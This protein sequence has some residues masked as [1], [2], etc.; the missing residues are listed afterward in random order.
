MWHFSSFSEV[1]FLA[2]QFFE[3]LIEEGN[4]SGDSED[5]IYDIISC[6]Q[7]AVKVVSS[8]TLIRSR[9]IQKILPKAT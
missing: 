6:V 5:V 2:L 8:I 4:C 1:K 9:D 7:L 3:K